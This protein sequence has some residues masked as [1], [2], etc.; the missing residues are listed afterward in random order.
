MKLFQ[1]KPEIQKY[2]NAQEF[3]EE[4]EIGEG[5]FILASK[6]IYQK[7]F[8]DFELSAEV[9]FKGEYGSGEP[10]DVMVDGLLADFR[11]TNCNRIVAIGGGAVIDMAKILVL[12]G[13]FRASEY[14]QKQVSLKKVR[15]LIAV[16]TTCGAGSES[17]NISIAE[18]TEMHTKFGLADDAIYPDYA[19]LIP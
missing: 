16:P 10:T 9:H 12:E 8:T 6:S 13:G 14:Y 2:H 1:Q 17:S 19:V 5:D 3:V 18:I 7:Y 4:F 15:T 11:K